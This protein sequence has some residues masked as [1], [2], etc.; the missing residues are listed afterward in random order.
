[1]QCINNTSNVPNLTA[2][3]AHHKCAPETYIS[4]W[5]G[6]TIWYKAYFMIKCWISC[7][8]NWQQKWKTEGLSVSGTVGR[9]QVHPRGI[10]AD[11]GPWPPPTTPEGRAAQKPGEDQQSHVQV[12]FQPN[13]RHF[14]I[15][16]W[17]IKLNHLQLAG[18]LQQSA[19]K[20]GR[21]HRQFVQRKVQHEIVTA[22]TCELDIHVQNLDLV[23]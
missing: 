15:V 3:P 18:Y 1:M 9:V 8:I 10:V 16:K 22:A 7:I 14:H 21:D 12:Q 20:L 19:S 5:L 13:V 17:K 4:L 6:K 11:G 2:L 23:H